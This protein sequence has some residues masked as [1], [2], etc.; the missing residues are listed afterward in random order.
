MTFNCTIVCF[1]TFISFFK[2][3]M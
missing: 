2:W 1:I 3:V